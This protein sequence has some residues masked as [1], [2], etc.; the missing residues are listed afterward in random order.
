[1]ADIVSRWRG[2]NGAVQ[3]TIPSS[4]RPFPTS[5]AT[6]YI[7]MFFCSFLAS[8]CLVFAFTNELIF[9]STGVSITIPRARCPD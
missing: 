4:Q 2:V 8:R 9:I 6:W 3:P 5:Q 7:I 1:M